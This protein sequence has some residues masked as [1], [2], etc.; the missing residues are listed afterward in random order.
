MKNSVTENLID[1][2]DSEHYKIT[3]SDQKR[4]VSS[5]NGIHQ[6]AGTVAAKKPMSLQLQVQWFHF[7]IL[8]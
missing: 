5:D 4:N 7:K 3:K 2:Y 1:L 8:M 6:M